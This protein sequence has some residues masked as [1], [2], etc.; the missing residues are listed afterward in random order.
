VRADEFE[1]GDPV[2]VVAGVESKKG[3]PLFA[4]ARSASRC[5]MSRLQPAPRILGLLAR[6]RFHRVVGADGLEPP[7]YAL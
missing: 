2:G 7:T 5:T 3:E 4:C 1:H 6:R